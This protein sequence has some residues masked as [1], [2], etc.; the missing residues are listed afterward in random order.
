MRFKLLDCPFTLAYMDQYNHIIIKYAPYRGQ[1]ID[2]W[3]D[4]S[5]LKTAWPSYIVNL[6][7]N[8]SLPDCLHQKQQ[9][10]LLLQSSLNQIIV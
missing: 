7:L 4:Y 6:S 5:L 9:K 3:Y 8:V 10:S 1:N 2:D